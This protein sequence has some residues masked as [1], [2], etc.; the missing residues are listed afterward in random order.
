MIKKYIFLVTIF[1]VQFLFPQENIVKDNTNTWFTILNRLTINSKWSVSN[2]LHERQ[3]AFYSEHATFLWR[4]SIDYHLNADV[5]I[6]FGYSYINNEPN[7]PNINPK[8]NAIENNIWEQVLLKHKIGKVNFQHRFRQEHRWYDK[9]TMGSSG[10]FRKS[11]TDFANRFRYRITVNT[12][13]KTFDNGKEIF[14]QGFDEIW[15]L[16]TEGLAPKSFSRNWLYLGLGY[17]FNAKTNL[18][19]GYMNQ[20][21]VLG[22]DNY[23]ST[24][25][26]QTTFI[27]N[28]DLLYKKNAQ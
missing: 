13:I 3:G 8:I 26:I 17:K 22:N 9:I 1:S 28:F 2:E 6:S 20:W 18:Q 21:D 23:V 19:L 25:I 14:F 16:Q 5:E 10:N 7:K 24:P 27:R 12:P 11:G 15:I 4:P